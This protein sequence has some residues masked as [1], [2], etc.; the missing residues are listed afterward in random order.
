MVS[1]E[2]QGFSVRIDCPVSSRHF[3]IFRKAKGLYPL[4]IFTASE[5]RFELVVIAQ[6]RHK[7]VGWPI[8][9]NE[10][11]CQVAAAFEKPFA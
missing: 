9:E 5:Q 8:L 11:K 7:Q 1:T 2:A 10:A 3:A 4:A 6:E